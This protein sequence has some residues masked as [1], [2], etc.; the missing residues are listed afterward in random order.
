M[1][2]KAFEEIK[3]TLK[4]KWLDYYEVNQ[5]WIKSVLKNKKG[6]GLQ[7][8]KNLLIVRSISMIEPK[9]Q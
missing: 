4:D 6:E 2:F 3:A 9:L 5:E 1:T 7:L 8:A